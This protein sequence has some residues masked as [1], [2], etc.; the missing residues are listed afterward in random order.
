MRT[1]S[2]NLPL[3]RMPSTNAIRIYF[4]NTSWDEDSARPSLVFNLK[5]LF[6]IAILISKLTIRLLQVFYFY[7][8]NWR[9]FAG[10]WFLGGWRGFI[11][12]RFLGGWRG[13]AGWTVFRRLVARVF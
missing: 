6:T 3:R 13:F 1:L 2:R 5:H 4:V 9:S 8:F 11:G 10:L 12:L 7:R